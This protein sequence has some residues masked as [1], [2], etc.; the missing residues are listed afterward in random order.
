[1]HT[2]ISQDFARNVYGLNFLITVLDHMLHIHLD[3]LTSHRFHVY[4][5][6][7]IVLDPM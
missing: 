2:P 4:T 5:Q 6:K 7:E 3:Y 1:M